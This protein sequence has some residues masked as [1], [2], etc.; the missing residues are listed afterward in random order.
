MRRDPARR[1]RLERGE[2]PRGAAPR[3]CSRAPAGSR[4]SSTSARSAAISPTCS[5][6]HRRG[7]RAAS[8]RSSGASS[9]RRPPQGAVRRGGEASAPRRWSRRSTRQARPGDRARRR[10][11]R[12]VAATSVEYRYVALDGR[13]DR[14]HRRR[15]RCARPTRPQP[16]T[17]DELAKAGVGAWALRAFRELDDALLDLRFNHPSVG[18]VAAEDRA[19]TRPRCSRVDALLAKHANDWLVREVAA[20]HEARPQAPRPHREEPLRARRA[21][22]VL[23]RHRSS[24]SR[25]PPTA[26][27]CSTTTDE[28]T[29]DRGSRR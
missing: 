6:T 22:L 8:A 7:R 25:S 3:A 17:P 10:S 27:T 9:T 29:R 16:Q 23:R 2:P 4:A 20:P 1:R 26:S 13:R 21:G 15:S 28:P 24:S 5:R 18:V 11:S 14:A 19:A 12:S